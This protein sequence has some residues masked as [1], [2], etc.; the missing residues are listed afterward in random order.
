MNT[1]AVTP[2]SDDLFTI[3]KILPKLTDKKTDY[4]H[5][6][7]E[8]FLFAARRAWPNIQVAVAYPCTWVKEPTELDY[9]KLTRLMKYVRATL[10][11]PLII[12]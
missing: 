10:H 9:H 2:A 6:I 11:L 3:D 8:R 1:T 12:G 4:F 7:T 5:Q